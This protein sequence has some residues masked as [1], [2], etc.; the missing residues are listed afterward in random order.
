M[1]GSRPVLGS[2]KE[3]LRL[4][5]DRAGESHAAPHAAELDGLFFPTSGN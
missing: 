5:R 4:V 2:S 3:D 1:I